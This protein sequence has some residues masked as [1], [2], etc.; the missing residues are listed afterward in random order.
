MPFCLG[1][2]L[3]SCFP[4]EANGLFLLVDDVSKKKNQ[5][6]KIKKKNK[7]RLGGGPA[8]PFRSGYWVRNERRR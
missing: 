6:K 7:R 1:E 2:R 4:V 3:R 5:K 8:I